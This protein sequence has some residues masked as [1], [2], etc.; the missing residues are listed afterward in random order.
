[1]FLDGGERVKKVYRKLPAWYGLGWA[2]G[3]RSVLELPPGST[4]GIDLQR[5]DQILIT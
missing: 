5:G 2:I 1:V 4:E 3:A